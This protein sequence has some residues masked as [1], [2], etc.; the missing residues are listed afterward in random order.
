MASRA[1][2]TQT[3]PIAGWD[4]AIAAIALAC[5]TTGFWRLWPNALPLNDAPLG[6]IILK[7]GIAALGF[8]GIA[9]R[10]EDTL[11][12]TLRN[13]FGIVMIV[14]AC[15]SSIWAI[16]PSEAL[17][18]GILFLVI[19]GFGI[20]LSLRFK[21]AELAEICGFAGI[22]GVVMQV[23]AH[24]GLPSVDHFDGDLAFALIGSVWAAMAVRARRTIWIIAAGLCFAFATASTE[25][26]AM[27]AVLGFAFGI[28][29]AAFGSALGKRGAISVLIAAWIIVISVIGLTIFLMFSAAPI[30]ESVSRY[31][32][33]LGDAMI[34]GQGFGVTGQSVGAS[35][36]GGLGL[37]GTAVV[38]LVVLSTFFQA[39]FGNPVGGNRLYGQIGVFFACTG[40]LVV[41]P[42]EVAV[43]GP[44][45]VLFAATSFKLSLACAPLARPRRALFD[46]RKQRQVAPV[47]HAHQTRAPRPAVLA[48]E[49]QLSPTTLKL[50]PR[51]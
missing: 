14:L 36:G 2:P 43:F 12:A 25:K 9:S 32:T 48:K 4:I 28:G 45:A 8:V 34:I 3:N 6:P 11:Q 19:W 50:R 42:Q 1:L 46:S 40:T 35:F 23:T 29:L 49:A 31:F 33:N 20:A 47:R 24:K 17:R 30:G 22:F 44:V 38:A 27:G 10:W 13:P 15:A 51:Q 16:A 39:L 37:L 21:P 26:A 41:A 7:A 18:N 5:M